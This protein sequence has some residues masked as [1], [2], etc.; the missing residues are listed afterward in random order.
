MASQ[1]GDMV[2]TIVLE[3]F[4]IIAARKQAGIDAV[5]KRYEGLQSFADLAIFCQALAFG[6][7]ATD[8]W[9][10][11]GAPKREGPSLTKGLHRAPGQGRYSTCLGGQGI[12]ASGRLGAREETA[13]QIR[14]AK[15]MV[16]NEFPQVLRD[17]KN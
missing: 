1:L 17:R 10:V 4:E 6:L 12:M 3:S 9:M 11:L 5:P 14:L 2:E 7:G 13:R 15:N 16:L 8:P